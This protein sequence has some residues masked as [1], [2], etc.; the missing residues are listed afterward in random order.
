MWREKY[1]KVGKNKKIINENR[2]TYH[3]ER[4]LHTMFSINAHTNKLPLQYPRHVCNV[5]SN[6]DQKNCQANSIAGWNHSSRPQQYHLDNGRQ[7]IGYLLRKKK[8]IIIF[9]ATLHLAKNLFTWAIYR[10]SQTNLSH[11]SHYFHLLFRCLVNFAV[12]CKINFSDKFFV[13]HNIGYSRF[14]TIY[15]PVSTKAKNPVG[16]EPTTSSLLSPN[17][18]ISPIFIFHFNFL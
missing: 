2:Q 13:F 7:H 6:H 8:I 17:C 9:H 3:F 14:N 11:V 5:L 1:G 18:A 15:L 16:L 10:L 12:M 4:K